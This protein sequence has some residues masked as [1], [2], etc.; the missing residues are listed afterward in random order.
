[1]GRLFHL[2]S[3]MINQVKFVGVCVRD[4]ER[5]LQFYTQKLG[6]TVK[7]DQAMGP[8]RWI[9]LAIPGAETGVV[10]FTPPGQEDRIGVFVH[11]SLQCDNLESTYNELKSRGVEF[12]SPPQTQPWGSFAIMKDPDGNSFVL[13]SAT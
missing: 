6:F 8:Q 3:L 2:E 1:M 10:L 11:T 5:A 4:Q 12:A 9:E 7:T 13:S